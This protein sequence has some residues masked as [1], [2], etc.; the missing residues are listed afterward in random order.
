MTRVHMFPRQTLRTI[1][2]VFD[3]RLSLA[4]RLQ[5]MRHNRIPLPSAPKSPHPPATRE[6]RP[7]KHNGMN[8]P[9]LPML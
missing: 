5:L 2:R 8:I 3:M 6:H 9:H 7:D 4:L 1:L